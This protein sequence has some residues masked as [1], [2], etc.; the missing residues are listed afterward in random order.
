MHKYPGVIVY[1]YVEFNI[2]KCC[3]FNSTTR[4]KKY[5]GLKKRFQNQIKIR[6][7]N[8][9]QWTHIF[10]FVKNKHEDR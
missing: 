6:A 4:L 10:Q 7:S 8:Q 9:F 3:Q 2:I 5:Q 1:S